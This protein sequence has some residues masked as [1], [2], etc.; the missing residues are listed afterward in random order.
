MEIARD[1]MFRKPKML[2]GRAKE[3]ADKLGCQPDDLVLLTVIY[4]EGELPDYAVEK[5]EGDAV[6]W[7]KKRAGIPN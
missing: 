5:V 3:E 1:S 4:K 2:Q 6:G 7:L